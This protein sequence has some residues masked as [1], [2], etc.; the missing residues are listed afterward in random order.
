M[1]NKNQFI[2]PMAGKG[3]TLIELLIVIAI[4]AIIAAIVFVSLDPLTR[5]KKARDARRWSDVVNILH[6]VKL[7]QVDNGGA[8]VASISGLAAGSNYTI[9]TCANG[10]NSGCTAVATQAACADLT[11]LVTEGYMGAVPMDPST[12][13]ASKTDYYI[14]RASTGILTI[15]AC[16]PED[17][18]AISVSR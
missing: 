16:D 13:S 8:Y 11:A 4:I 9:G 3:F 14:N 15:G 17:A 10:G 12:G 2:T 5:F 7:D 18:S 6:A 1:E